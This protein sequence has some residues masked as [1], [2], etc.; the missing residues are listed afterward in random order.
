MTRG[1]WLSTVALGLLLGVL[2]LAAATARAVSEGERHMHQSDDAFDRGDLPGALLHAR[3]AAVMYAPGAPHVQSAYNRLIAIA[4]GAEAAGQKRSAETAWRAV[5]GAAL[6]TRHLWVVRG[7][8]LGRANENLARLNV[9][10]MEASDAGDPREALARAR[11]ELA[12]DNAPGLVWLAALI[13]G[14]VATAL[15]LGLV[16]LRGVR[17]DGSFVIGRAKV[18]ML[19][20]IAGALAW[21][22]AV[23]RA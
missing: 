2:V 16:A 1:R 8:E 10:G 18:G 20:A 3:A 14:F 19:L 9:A 23:W 4:V 17:P 21:T 5:R 11:Q 22:T 13:A 12:R 6:E 7:A 15:G